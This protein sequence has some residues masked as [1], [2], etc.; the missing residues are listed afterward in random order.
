MFALDHL[1]I[2]RWMT[3]YIRDMM[4]LEECHLDVA[5]EFKKGNFVVKK[6]QH[7]LSGISLDHAHEQNTKL[8]KGDGG[9]YQIYTLGYCLCCSH[10]PELGL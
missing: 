10:R 5:D 2:A 8:V 7:A 6:T 1:K 4:L 3:L 9:S